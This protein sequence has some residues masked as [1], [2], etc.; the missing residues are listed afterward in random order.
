EEAS[1]A[2]ANDPEQ[3]AWYRRLTSM[4]EAEPVFLDCFS[5]WRVERPR[6]AALPL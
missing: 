4:T 2:T 1:E 6:G 3:D 5:A